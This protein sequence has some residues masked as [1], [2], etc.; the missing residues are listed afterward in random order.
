MEFREFE[1]SVKRKN[2]INLFTLH[3]NKRDTIGKTDMLI[4]I[5]AEILQRL[6]FIF[7]I[8]PAYGEGLRGINVLCPLNGKAVPR[9]PAQQRERFIEHKIAGDAIFAVRAQFLPDRYGAAMM[10]IIE[11]VARQ[12]CPGVDENHFSSPY[13][14]LLEN[15]SSY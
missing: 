6:D 2:A 11:E 4:R 13:R 3:Q 8:G 7:P 9:P 10:L 1:M 15:L 12:E 5:F 14:Y